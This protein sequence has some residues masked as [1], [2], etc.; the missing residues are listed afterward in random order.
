ML[1]YLLIFECERFT[2]SPVGGQK[3]VPREGAPIAGVGQREL[4][5]RCPSPRLLAKYST[6][7]KKRT[8]PVSKTASERLR[9]AFHLPAKRREWSPRRSHGQ[10]YG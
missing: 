6:N 4:R 9:K 2:L 8:V 5:A 10:G 7:Q 1:Q 3:P